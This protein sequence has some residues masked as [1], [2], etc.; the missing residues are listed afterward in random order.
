VSVLATRKPLVLDAPTS[1]LAWLD[2]VLHDREDG[3]VKLVRRVLNARAAGLV[4]EAT[5]AT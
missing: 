3:A 5:A 4:R 2:E 1:T